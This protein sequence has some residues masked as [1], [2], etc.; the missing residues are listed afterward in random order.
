MHEPSTVS[1][2]VSDLVW[3]VPDVVVSRAG[4]ATVAFASPTTSSALL[5]ILRLRVTLKTRRMGSR[6]RTR[7]FAGVHLGIDG[8][9]V[10]TVMVQ[11]FV[12][13]LDDS[14][15]SNE[16]VDVILPDRVPGGEWSSS[17]AA[18][19]ERELLNGAHLAVSASGA[20]VLMWLETSYR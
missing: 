9:D 16:I 20:A 14:G 18:V 6:T 13:L 1:E 7:Q 4:T 3:M 11:K 5:M 10:Q 19:S 2:S 17:S 15:S 12:R 8:A